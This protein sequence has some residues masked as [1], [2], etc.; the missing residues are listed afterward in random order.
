MQIRYLFIVVP[1]L[2]TG[3]LMAQ[4]KKEP[5]IEMMGAPSPI[6]DFRVNYTYQYPDGDMAH[7]FGNMHNIGAAFFYKTKSN[8]CA[9][10]E[11]GYQF[12]SVV[13]EPGLLY[14][15][16]NSTGYVMNTGGYPANYYLSERGMNF[17][18]RVGKIFPL[19]VN[20]PNS[21]ILIMIGGGYYLH[22]IYIN[23]KS[24]D[25]PTLTADLKKG[26][27]RLTGGWGI[28][29]FVGYIFHSESR[30]VNF[31][32]GMELV[33]AYTKSLRGYNYDQMATDTKQ[34]Y[35]AALGFRFGWIL[36]IYLNSKDEDE[37]MFR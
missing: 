12:G 5:S 2:L 14:Y 9:D 16:T 23:T 8:L 13:K 24:N 10:L 29:E 32:I 26:Y 25:I 6:L 1:M 36:P 11:L 18:G 35:D 3:H 20:S 33:Q 28:S 31:Y 21:G 7:R 4:H 27:D 30:Y 17:T 22:K 37:F 34:R 19:S 15:L